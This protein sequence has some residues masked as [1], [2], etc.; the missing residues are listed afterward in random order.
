MT[1]QRRISFIRRL[2]MPALAL[3]LLG[4]FGYHAFTGAFG[5]WAKEGLDA[6]VVRLQGERDRL[7]AEADALETR[8]AAVRPESLDPDM[9]DLLARQSLSLM[10]TDEI[11]IRMGAP[12]Q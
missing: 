4:Y 11:A 2:W 6:D 9:V 7:T 12:Q 10:R 8:V 1:R 5:I 3:S